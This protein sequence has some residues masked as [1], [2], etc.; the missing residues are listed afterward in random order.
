MNQTIE[1]TM[2]R[3]RQY[4]YIDGFSEM[5]TGLVFLLLGIVNCISG[6]VSPSA[7]SAVMVGIGYPLIILGGTFAGRG[8]VRFLKEK[9][10]YPRTGFVK[11]IQPERS[12]RTK[13]IVTAFF[14]AISVSI[15]T[16][17]VLRGLD[18]YW[19]VL[20]TGLIIAAFI[21]YLGVQVPL[22]RFFILALW[23]VVVSLISASFPLSEDI[24]MGILLGGSGL[25]WLVSGL[26]T[27]LSYMKNTRPA[28]TG[29]EED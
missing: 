3:T 4:W 22:N 18:P 19:V 26:I 14:V 24:Q 29:L 12:S 21:G 5:L 1:G 23:V 13:R 11:Y 7:G 9:I 15:V 20:G 27:L 28:K 8:W 6:I 16:M 10:T 17:V 2:Q 25:G